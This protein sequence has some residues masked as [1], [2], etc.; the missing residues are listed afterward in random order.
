VDM[1]T[2]RNKL[3]K[4]VRCSTIMRGSIVTFAIIYYN[5]CLELV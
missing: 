1:E 2:K 4:S 3:K 5:F